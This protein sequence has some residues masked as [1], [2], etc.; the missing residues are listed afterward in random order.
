[1]PKRNSDNTRIKR[2]Y[3][4]WL[5]EAKGQ[6]EASVS[7]A[8][9]SISAYEDFLDGKDFRTLHPERARAFK[10]TLEEKTNTKTGSKLSASTHSAILRDVKTFFLWLADQPGYKSKI[11]HDLAEYFAPPRRAETARRGGLWKPHP[12]PEDALRAIR[13]MPSE[14]V[15]ER[16]D[17]ALMAFLVLTGSREG[18]AI[19]ICLGQ[20]EL[21]SRCVHFDARSVDTKFG[22]SFSTG[23][24]P[25]GDEAEAILGDWVQ[26]LKEM[27][28]S[29]A[30][31]LFPKTKVGVGSDRKFQAQGLLREPWASPSSLVKIFKRAFAAI[32]LP[33]FPPHR[34]RDTIV[35][36][37]QRICR[38]PEEFKSWSQNMGHSDVLTT[39]MSYGSVPVGRQMELMDRFRKDSFTGSSKDPSK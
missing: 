22:K 8:S 37:G 17:R 35:E 4:V 2:K 39:F 26:E 6:A 32:G 21:A 23:F 19:S 15:I 25:F 7:K 11:S 30:D 31:P 18:A 3:L 1:M 13:A 28:F 12:S 14:T 9:A 33:P 5:R 29:S 10:R 24:Y 20:I 16:R 38:T 36:L 34:I 27:G